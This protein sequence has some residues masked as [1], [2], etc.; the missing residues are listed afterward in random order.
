LSRACLS[1]SAC[2]RLLISSEVQAKWMNSATLATSRLAASLSRRKYSTA[3]TSWLVFASIVLT[4]SPSASENLAATS[5]SCASV[6]GEN[7]GTSFTVGFAASA[8][9]HSIST[10]TRKRI[11]AYS[12]NVSRNAASLL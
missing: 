9:S 5:S 6:G 3:L 8:L 7:G 10:F 2:E 12:L 1:I 11:S 4:V